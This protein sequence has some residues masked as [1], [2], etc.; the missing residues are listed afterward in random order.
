MIAGEFKQKGDSS[1]QPRSVH[2]R[3]SLLSDQKIWLNK[4][5]GSKISDLTYGTFDAKAKLS[6]ILKKVEQGKEIIIT[7]HGRAVAKVVP[8]PRG[9]KRELGFG[10]SDVG[11]LPGW[12][13]PLTAED[14]LGE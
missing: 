13:V 4:R 11:F 7:R 3:H 9:G 8:V 10:A 1:K 2:R 5:V 6:E 14:L 12:D